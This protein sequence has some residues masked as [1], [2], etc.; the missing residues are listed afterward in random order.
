MVNQ[1]SYFKPVQ[2]FKRNGATLILITNR[3]GDETDVK[4]TQEQLVNFGIFGYKSLYFRFPKKEDNLWKVLVRV[5][6]NEDFTLS[7]PLMTNHM[8]LGN[9]EG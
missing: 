5:Y 2:L 8:I 9:T 4:Y 1:F 7:R 3:L 6:L